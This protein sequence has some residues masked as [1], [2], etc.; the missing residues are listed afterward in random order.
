MKKLTAIFL[1]FGLVIML[2]SFVP[3]GE[4]EKPWDVPEEYQ[5]WKILSALTIRK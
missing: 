5:T 4:G 3:Q 1:T 2:S